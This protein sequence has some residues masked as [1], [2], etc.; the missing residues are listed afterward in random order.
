MFSIIH[1]S[2][3]RGTCLLLCLLY[4]LP[5]WSQSSDITYRTF[6]SASPDIQT[7]CYWYWLAGNVSK[8]GVENDLRTMK[9]QGINRAFI[10]I[11]GLGDD[12]V[13]RGTVRF[14]SEQWWDVLQHAFRTASELG[15][16][17]GIFNGVGWSHMG[18]KWVRPEESMRYLAARRHD[19]R[20]GGEVSLTLT[21]ADNNVGE[22]AVLAY[23]NPFSHMQQLSKDEVEIEGSRMSVDML[24]DDD[25][26]VMSNFTGKRASM[27]IRIKRKDFTLRAIHLIPGTAFRA[28]VRVSARINGK[29]QLLKTFEINRTMMEN[30][31]GYDIFAPVTEALPNVQTEELYIE[32]SD[33]RDRSRLRRII[34]SG[35]PTISR[36][37]EKK[38]ARMFQTPLPYW[39]EYKWAT[40]HNYAPDECVAL[41]DIVDLGPYINNGVLRWQAPAGDWTIM[42]LYMVPTGIVCSPAFAEDGEGLE[43][44]R[45]SRAALQHHYDAY[46][47]EIERR[48][49]AEDRK[50][51]TTIVCDS[52]EKATQNYGDD[53]LP[54]FR[55]HFGYDALPYLLT[56]FGVVVG[57][58]E[59]SD[60]FLWDVR[61]MIA[62]RLAM[63][64]IAAMDSIA[65]SRGKHLWLENY[66]H[67]GFPGEFLQY[68]SRS[69]EIGGEFWSSGSLGDI[70]N[71]TASSCAHIYGKRR[72][73]AESFTVGGSEFSR[74]PRDFKQRGDRFFAEG[75]NNTLLHV[76]ISQRNEDSIPDIIPWFGNEF[77][78]KNTWYGHLHLFTDYLKRCNYLLQQGA[79]VADVAYYIGEDAPCM[80]DITEPAL[81][82]GYQY[83]YIN[84]EVMTTTL[85]ATADHLFT[86]PYGNRYR[87][88]VLPPSTTMRPAVLRAVHQLIADGG[89]VLGPKPQHS[90]SLQGFPQCDEEV[91][92]LADTM[93]GAEHAG[94]VKR[95]IG[96][97]YLLS[98]YS[99]EEVMRMLGVK[100]DCQIKGSDSVVYCHVARD[101]YRPVDDALL[102]STLFSD[103]AGDDIGDIYFIANQAH[104]PA[105]ISVALRTDKGHPELWQAVDGSRRP[106]GHYTRH[107]GMTCTTLNLAPLESAFIVFR[108]GD[109][110]VPEAEEKEEGR[111]PETIALNANWTVRFQSSYGVD[112]TLTMPALRDWTSYADADL[113]YFGGRGLYSNTFRLSKQQVNRR[114]YLEL[115]GLHNICTVQVNGKAVG[116]L[117]TPPYRLNIT[118]AVRQGKNTVEIDVANNLCNRMIG[119]QA[120]PSHKCL[121]ASHNTWKADSS[122]QPSGITGSVKIVVE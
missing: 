23:R 89:V 29:E 19:V 5:L 18:G 53:F 1:S 63:D 15:V 26:K 121:T 13:P 35:E 103:N 6:S 47:G 68:G 112:T 100:P 2:L 12:E 115:E 67:W 72:V 59:Q 116:G 64:N 50:T 36:Y 86:L 54:Y 8:T 49:P 11:Q 122:L 71:R 93:W 52:Y 4:F 32:F 92:A 57:S 77:N 110:M 104:T 14:M 51:W 41:Q 108:T 56:Y 95:Q 101:G 48:I 98:G 81:P 78:R 120:D 7:S 33:I 24:L 88:L 102:P 27:R 91:K 37:S 65:R 16:E 97:G 82:R 85:R 83:D 119:D 3:C 87:L 42:Q 66:G 69:T 25:P 46:M 99:I 107:N 70:E 118:A 73:S 84:A 21:S 90:P 75:I 117:W 76:Y 10:G 62:D 40:E 55:Q 22:V 28:H 80:T 17:L 96:K 61:R 111:Q 31:T 105:D 106:I 58:E 20:G 109:E 60:R 113:R 79:Y 9:A 44:D 43:V 45:W 114:V 34:L 38:L 30:I 74:S 39:K 94:K